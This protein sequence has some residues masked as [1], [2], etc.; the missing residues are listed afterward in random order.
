MQEAIVEQ[1]ND[2]LR[3]LREA[4]LAE[5]LTEVRVTLRELRDEERAPDG[6]VQVR[7]ILYMMNTVAV[8]IAI[9]RQHHAHACPTASRWHSQK[10]CRCSLRMIT[11]LNNSDVSA[12]LPGVVAC[13]KLRSAL[14][15]LACWHCRLHA[16]TEQVT[17]TWTASS[18]LCL[19]QS[20]R[21]A[22]THRHAGTCLQNLR[23]MQA[24]IYRSSMGI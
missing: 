5:Q 8:S 16:S 18:S 13:S 19:R 12:C 22:Q 17:L 21:R 11:S 3:E 4:G 15:Y 14:G 6:T 24:D 20:K 23:V 1:Y 10:D 9:G 2:Q 7:P